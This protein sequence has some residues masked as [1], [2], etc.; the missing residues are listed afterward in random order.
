MVFELLTSKLL[1]NIYYFKSIVSSSS[2]YS[3][4]PFWSEIRMYLSKL[5][6]IYMKVKI[7]LH[8]SLLLSIIL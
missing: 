6:Q 8:I 5:F 1:G 4:I 7:N 2:E 3:I